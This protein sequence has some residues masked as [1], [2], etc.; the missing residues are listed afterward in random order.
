MLGPL[1]ARSA[2]ELE[3]KQSE[4]AIRESEQRY[5]AFIATNMDAMAR[6]EFEEPID[7]T[8]SANR[9]HIPVWLHRR[10]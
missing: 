7:T 8:A 10:V 4:Q 6:I 2:A 5:R 9:R 1:A 3:R